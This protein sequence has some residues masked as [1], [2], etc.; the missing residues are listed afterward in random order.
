MALSDDVIP[1]APIQGPNV[2][3]GAFGVPVS[4]VG[5]WVL[6]CSDLYASDNSGSE[7]VSPLLIT[8]TAQRKFVVSGVGTVLMLCMKYRSN[9]TTVTQMPVVQ[10][11]GL[12][13]QGVPNRLRDASG[14]HALTLTAA[15]AT[16]VILGSYKYTVP[17]EVDMDGAEK[18]LVA[19]K[20]PV[21]T[22]GGTS[23]AELWAKVK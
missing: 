6:I 17:V 23:E 21:T 19:V 18:V 12:D 9:I 3:D 14:T 10:P 8:R 7:V 22:S 11:F 20:T 15:T 2:R 5:R 1:R 16:D 13:D 4:V